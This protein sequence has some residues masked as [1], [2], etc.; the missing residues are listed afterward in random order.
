MAKKTE[1]AKV[2][3]IFNMQIDNIVKEDKKGEYEVYKPSAKDGKDNNYKAIIRFIPWYKEVNKSIIDKWTVWLT[4]A[5]TEES[6]YID[7]P[8]TVGEPSI[9]QKLFFDL[10]NSPNANERELSQ[11]FGRRQV[12]HS[13]IQIINDQNNPDLNGK[14]KVFK[15]GKK[16]YDRI[17]SVLKPQEGME[18]ESN[19]IFDPFDARA[20]LLNIKIVAGFNNYDDSIFVSKVSPII[21]DGKSVEKKKEM[22]PKIIKFLE[23]NSPDLSKYDYKPWDEDTK[24]FVFD[25]IKSII[26]PGK[27]LESLFKKTSLKEPAIVKKAEKDLRHTK[28]IEIIEKE[29]TYDTDD[30]D[31]DIEDDDIDAF[32]NGT[33]KKAEPKSSKK[34]KNTDDLDLDLNIDVDKDNEEDEDFDLYKDL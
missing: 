22:Y 33:S 15:Y 21:I 16:I 34:S 6:R 32:L 4:N 11:N 19:N 20:F 13:L 29:E 24:E 30:V 1:E 23:E 2:S 17:K 10:R 9:L 14:I 8:S 25:A 7:C 3:D 28:K 26:P 31:V 5:D 27:I 18:E 12:F